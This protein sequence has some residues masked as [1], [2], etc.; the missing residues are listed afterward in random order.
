MLI[1]RV[2][3]AASNSE[4][5][6]EAPCMDVPPVMFTFVFELEGAGEVVREVGVDFEVLKSEIKVPAAEGG[7][8]GMGAWMVVGLG[9]EVKALLD[10]GMEDDGMGFLAM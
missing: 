10:G 3:I 1:S 8:L 4:R 9:W 6:V 2:R 7:G 5:T